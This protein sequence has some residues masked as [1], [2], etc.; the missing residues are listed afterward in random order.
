MRDDNDNQTPEEQGGPGQPSFPK[1]DAELNEQPLRSSP[2]ANLYNEIQHTHSTAS[3]ASSSTN[4][5][6]ED[7]DEDGGSDEGEGE[8]EEVEVGRSSLKAA[9]AATGTPGLLP[10][11]SET[12]MG[13][14]APL[15]WCLPLGCF[16]S[17]GLLM[18]SLLCL[19][20]RRSLCL[21]MMIVGVW[22]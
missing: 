18:L 6:Y 13:W 1:P 16:W 21:M 15:L 9:N 5:E 11:P 4:T 22:I 17:G 8:G 10:P 12:V 20:R 19:R 14:S 7:E 3:I 2:V